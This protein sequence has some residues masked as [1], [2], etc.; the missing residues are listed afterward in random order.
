MMKIIQ[1][2][3]NSFALTLQ[4]NQ[5]VTTTSYLFEFIKNSTG[6]K[7][8]CVADDLDD[9]YSYRYN[10]ISITEMSNPNILVGEIRLA[11]T[12]SYTY[13][14]Y[15]N[16]NATNTDPANTTKLL[17][18]GMAKV[19]AATTYTKTFTGTNTGKTFTL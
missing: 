10:L 1:G 9:T 19:F 2:Q 4:E 3:S 11:E 18:T 15:Q 5:T 13:K 7:F 8:Y 6:Q 17:E 16:P 14:V 12:G